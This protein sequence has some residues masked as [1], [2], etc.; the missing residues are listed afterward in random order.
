MFAGNVNQV[1]IG[2]EVFPDQDEYWEDEFGFSDEEEDGE[3]VS[4]MGHDLWDGGEEEPPHFEEEI[5]E[6]IDSRAREV[7]TQRLWSMLVFRDISEEEARGLPQLTCKYVYDWRKDQAT[8]KW[9]RRARMVSR[10]YK[11]L[12]PRRG[13]LFAATIAPPIPKMMAVWAL[14]HPG[15]VHY[16]ADI[17]DAFLTVD[18]PTRMVVTIPGTDRRVEILKLLPGQRV[19]AAEW[20]GKGMASCPVS[21]TLFA[22]TG[23]LAVAVHV[24]DLYMVGKQE[25]IDELLKSL[26]THMK[27][28]TSGP[29]GEPGDVFM[30]LKRRF[31][32]TNEGILITANDRY[33]AKLQSLVSEFR[34]RDRKV[35]LPAQYSTIPVSE[36]Q[37][38]DR[39]DA[40]KTELYRKAVGLLL[41]KPMIQFPLKNLASKMSGP[42]ES[43]FLA[44]LHLIGF[45][46]ATWFQGSLLKATHPGAS[47]L[48][49]KEVFGGGHPR[50]GAHAGMQET[51]EIYTDSDWATCKHTRKSTTGGLA[52][53]D[54]N[55][56]FF[57][58]RT[59]R[60]VTT[61]SA[62]AEYVALTAGI[63]EGVWIQRVWDFLQGNEIT[64]GPLTE[65]ES[66]SPSR[67]RLVIRCDSAA[68]RAMCQKVGVNR[69]K[70][71]SVGLLWAQQINKQNRVRIAAVSTLV[72]PA[73]LF[74]KQ[75]S[76]QRMD[77]LM[78]IMR[79]IDLNTQQRVGEDTLYLEVERQ[80]TKVSIK[81]ALKVM[82]VRAKHFST[83]AKQG[84]RMAQ[85]AGMMF[86]P[87]GADASKEEDL[88]QSVQ[89]LQ[90]WNVVYMCAIFV[91]LFIL[92]FCLYKIFYLDRALNENVLIQLR[93]MDDYMIDHTNS[94]TRETEA[95]VESLR[96]E[97][98]SLHSA[99]NALEFAAGHDLY[100]RPLEEPGTNAVFTGERFRLSPGRDLGAASSVRGAEDDQGTE[101][102]GEMVERLVT[103]EQVQKKQRWRC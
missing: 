4:A 44:L 82:R 67:S 8:G 14:K 48:D 87:I 1:K 18:Q 37:Q 86:F 51:V 35:P 10:E 15:F 7:E 21:P 25:K 68:A 94:F 34:V 95:S 52:T 100:G 64:D 5:M 9:Y 83:A 33:L 88:V 42:N 58:S 29:F 2:D 73:D 74:T 103:T 56:V 46:Q 91:C 28:K 96:D 92:I 6:E 31:E 19:A 11:F 60:C 13:G 102:F 84:E 50:Q 97:V 70:H 75:L 93:E 12:D 65:E 101:S 38:K 81:E 90:W 20:A 39:L 61:S 22:K 59:Q 16:T 55:P 30:F 43:D 62:E 40:F 66:R 3:A 32:I 24:D 57:W 89:N 76:S 49:L 26:S 85:A 98:S 79:F 27:L 45:V 71:I 72:N 36:Q 54:A 80:A 17:S 78:C 41:D 23:D 53:I 99:V 63:Q 47:L 69:V 77:L